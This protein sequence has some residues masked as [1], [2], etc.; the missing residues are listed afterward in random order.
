MT[1]R[2]LVVCSSHTYHTVKSFYIRQARTRDI[3]DIL[4]KPRDKYL[5]HIHQSREKKVQL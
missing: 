2:I 5:N 1:F 4:S 3:H